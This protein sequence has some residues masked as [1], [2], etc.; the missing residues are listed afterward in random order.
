MYVFSLGGE[1][2]AYKQTNVARVVARVEGRTW[3]CIVQTN[4]LTIFSLEYSAGIGLGVRPRTKQ[5]TE[6]YATVVV[7]RILPLSL[8]LDSLSLSVRVR[9]AILKI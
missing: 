6:Q 9:R 5:I 1:R 2:D 4:T 3:V 8:S 7:W